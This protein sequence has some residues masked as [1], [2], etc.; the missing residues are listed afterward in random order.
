MKKELIEP[1]TVRDKFTFEGHYNHLP[2]DNFRIISE[3]E[4]AQ[5]KFFTYNPEAYD[6]RQVCPENLTEDVKKQIGERMLTVKLYFYH[7]G[8]GLGISSDFWAGKV[9]YFRFEA[10]DHNYK[11]TTIGKCL[12]RY[13]CSKCGYTQQIDSSD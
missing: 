9:Y 2:S 7:D 3:E 13:E 5:S 12:T 11:G 8:E 1:F 6:Y 4:F 10:C